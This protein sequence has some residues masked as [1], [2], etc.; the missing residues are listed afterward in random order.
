MGRIGSWRAAIVVAL[1]VVMVAGVVRAGEAIRYAVEPGLRYAFELETDLA[2]QVEGQGAM[3]SQRRVTGTLEV[4]EAVDGVP[5]RS[6]VVFDAGSATRVA[7]GQVPNPD[8]LTIPFGLAGR[9]VETTIAADGAV[10]I[11]DAASGRP[12]A[13]DEADRD[14][15]ANLVR[16]DE[17]LLPTD[18]VA[19]GDTWQARPDVAG[20]GM[21]Q[22]YR[23][24]VEAFEPRVGRPSVRLNSVAT[25]REDAHGLR[26]KA[27]LTGTATVDL[28]TGLVVESEASGPIRVR[29]SDGGNVGAASIRGE[30]TLRQ[31]VRLVF[32]GQAPEASPS[33]GAPEP[34]ATD[35]AEPVA[36]AVAPAGAGVAG[37]DW[38][39]QPGTRVGFQHPPG[40]TV[41]AGSGAVAIVPDDHDADRELI[42]ALGVE[43]GDVTDAASP[44]LA[45]QL[46]A[47]VAAPW[48]GMR[49]VGPPTP[50]RHDAG[51]AAKHT[52]RGVL[53]DGRPAASDVYV[54]V[55]DGKALSISIL[56]DAARLAERTPVVE[57]LFATVTAD[58][59]PIAEVDGDTDAD[60]K[61]AAVGDRRLIGMFRGEAINSNV[62]GVYINTQIVYA[63]GADGRVFN[64]AQS[65]MAAAKRDY[66]QDLV[67][68]AHGKSAGDVRSGAWQANGQILSIRWDDGKRATFAYG[69]EPDGSLVLRHPQTRKLIN[70]YPRVR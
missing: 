51:S 23:F 18:E 28:A 4:L 19:V 32:A 58:A 64:G 37:W 65:H 33:A 35:A 3:T 10:A 15:V 54:L 30:G 47:M 11:L 34:P 14:L 53:P 55:A 31:S 21:T 41:Q 61:R 52:Y 9:T 5:V 56:A 36:A 44:R 20:V 42:A 49:R 59:P 1:G 66:N 63:F 8:E 68:T 60:A 70:F 17:A 38:Y 13:L 39:R 2:M 69:F 46:D 6:R 45:A 57:R 16:V 27:E 40:W 24:T 43:A 48:P 50:I 7:G 29:G 26:T 25:I 67:W 62:E 22:R 12:V